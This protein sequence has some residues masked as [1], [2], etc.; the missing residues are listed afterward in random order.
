[1]AEGSGDVTVN[2]TVEFKL[3]PFYYKGSGNTAIQFLVYII[4]VAA[5]G[6]NIYISQIQHQAIDR[7]LND[8][9]ISS[10]LTPEQKADLPRLVKE[11]LEDKVRQKAEKVVKD[12]PLAGGSQ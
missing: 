4:L 2:G 7:G 3:G 8:V 12:A 9:F 10:L 1:M 6:Y 5:T 11:K